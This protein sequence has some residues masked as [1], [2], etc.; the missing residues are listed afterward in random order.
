MWT[1]ELWNYQKR[2]AHED[3]NTCGEGTTREDQE[4][5]DDEDDH[6]E[7]RRSPGGFSTSSN[8]Y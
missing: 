4:A 7:M 2:G 3:Q 5:K 1:T 8:R 6:D